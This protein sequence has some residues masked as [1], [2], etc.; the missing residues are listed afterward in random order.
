MPQALP[1]EGTLNP[2]SPSLLRL[3]TLLLG[4]H[5]VLYMRGPEDSC[6]VFAFMS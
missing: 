4:F 6:P 2:G 3:P 1:A 5:A